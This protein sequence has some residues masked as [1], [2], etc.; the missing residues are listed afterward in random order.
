MFEIPFYQLTPTE[1]LELARQKYAAAKET[2]EQKIWKFLIEWLSKSSNKISIKTSG[3]TGT[4]KTISHSK[5]NVKASALLT[6]NALDLMPNDNALLCLPADRIGGMM[7]I[8]RAQT[9]GLNLYC[10]KPSSNPIQLLDENIDVDFAA[11]TPMQLRAM[12]NDLHSVGNLNTIQKI[13]LGGENISDDLLTKIQTIRPEVYATFGMT[14]TISHIALKRLNGNKR[15]NHYK[16]FDGI[17]IAYDDRNCLVIDAPMLSAQ[18]IIT[19]DIVEIQNEKSFDWLGRWDNV[20]NSGGVKIL[21]EELEAKLTQNIPF[22][23]FIAGISDKLLG[24]KAVIVLEAD[25]VQ[26]NSVV[27]IINAVNLLPKLQRPKSIYA[28]DKFVMTETGKIKRKES[29]K[30]AKFIVKF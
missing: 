19:N 22:K 16:V 28:T 1:Q 4:P 8:V 10:L 24:E 15:D 18:K 9:I 3:S 17:N 25:S 23:F 29:L 5:K 21:S 14:E 27:P 11:F 26:L 2:W 30:A 12:L 6:K 7:M 13:I 20:I